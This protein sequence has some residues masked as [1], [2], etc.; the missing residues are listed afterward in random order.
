MH[1]VLGQAPSG[2]ADSCRHVDPIPPATVTVDQLHERAAP[3]ERASAL[4]PAFG[5]SSQPRRS[6]AL[7]RSHHD[8]FSR[9]ADALMTCDHFVEV[10]HA[11]FMA[12]FEEEPASYMAALAWFE[13]CI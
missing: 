13:R 10:A 1:A 9:L 6:A 12:A 8:V 4:L 2:P 3:G 11:R 7:P 5:L